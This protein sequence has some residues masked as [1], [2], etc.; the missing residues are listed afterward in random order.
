LIAAI[1]DRQQC[2]IVSGGNPADVLEDTMPNDEHPGRALARKLAKQFIER[3]EALN[4]KGKRRDNAALDFWCGA[5]TLAQQE[6]RNDVAEYL[7]RLA[8]LLIAVRG[9]IAIRDLAKD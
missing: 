2:A 9:Y 7:G 3:A 4:Y 6:E 5:A 1:D 8:V